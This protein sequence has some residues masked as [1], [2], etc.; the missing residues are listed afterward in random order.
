MINILKL[1]YDGKLS[2]DDA[3]EAI[4]EITDKFHRDELEGSIREDLKMDIH[5]W[6]AY[7][8]G[9]DLSILATWRVEGWP[10]FCANCMQII[11]YDDGFVILDEELVCTKC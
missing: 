5:E 1:V 8:Y 4:D 3:Y 6:T 7:A 2:E 10:R 9:I 11:N